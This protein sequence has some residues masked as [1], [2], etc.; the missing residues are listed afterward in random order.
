M[1]SSKIFESLGNLNA[2]GLRDIDIRRRRSP[3]PPHRLDSAISGGAPATVTLCLARSIYIYMYMPPPRGLKVLAFRVPIRTA[4]SWPL[5][6]PYRWSIILVRVK[7]FRHPGSKPGESTL[8]I[9]RY[10]SLFFYKKLGI[11]SLFFIFIIF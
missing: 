3:F 7:N 10:P 8:D 5:P 2:A 9:R 4:C 1:T 11:Y 6:Y